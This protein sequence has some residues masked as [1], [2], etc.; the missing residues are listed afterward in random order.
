[1]STFKFDQKGLKEVDK[2]MEKALALMGDDLQR[3]IRD[4]WVIPRDTG[5]LQNE[6]FSVD[7]K[8]ASKGVIRFTFSTPYAR[9]LYFHPE[10]DFKKTENPNAQAEWMK[11]WL[12]GGVYE[13]QPAEIYSKIL[14]K[15]L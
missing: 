2:K 4:A 5:V 15:E 3:V 1:M 11:P 14:S 6:G 8:D 13:K 9:R 12:K 7:K 10:Y